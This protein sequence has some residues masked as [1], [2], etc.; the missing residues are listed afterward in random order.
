MIGI[1]RKL[2]QLDVENKHIRVS[3]IGAGLMGKGMVSQ[4]M[5]MKGMIPALVASNKL[6]DA[7]AAYTLAGVKKEDIIIGRSLNQVNKAMEM[8]KLVATDI[9]EYATE[10]NLVDVVVDATGVPNVGAK[11]A[12]DAI[13]NGKHMVMLN[14][15]ADATI[16]PILNKLA[17]DAGVVYTGSAGD[18]PGAVMELFDFADAIGFDII[19]IGKGKNNPI[20]YEATPDSVLEKSKRFN[21]KPLR[22]ASFVDG[23][24]TMVELTSMAN[25]TGFVP[26]IQGGHGPKAQV[27]DLAQIFSLKED[28]GILDKSGIVD[29]V[30]G[31]A[32]GVFAVVTT[33]LPQ[34]KAE[35]EMVAMGKGPNYVLYRPYHL[36]SL[37]TPITIARA[38]IYNEATIAPMAGPVAEVVTRAKRDLKAGEYLDGIGEYTVLGSIDTYENAR[39]NN[40]VPIGLISPSTKV[41]RDIKKGELISLD[42]VELDTNTLIYQLKEQQDRIFSK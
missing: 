24:N 31:I 2:R 25:A 38:A 35:L 27:E 21:I 32:P 7:I 20:D 28:G 41:K 30:K 17:K 12:I 22:L 9:A 11:V 37:E 23:T 36:V 42:M 15:E 34:I 3:L 16:G 4:M 5:L 13:E 8:G 26:D 18:E 19:A 40:L 29:Y 33:D 10:A 14:V 6:E 1:N 39:R